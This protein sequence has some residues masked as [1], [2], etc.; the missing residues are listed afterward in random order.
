MSALTVRAAADGTTDTGLCD[1]DLQLDSSGQ[2]FPVT[3]TLGNIVTNLLYLKYVKIVISQ[4]GSKVIQIHITTFCDLSQKVAE[5][6]KSIQP[7]FHFQFLFKCVLEKWSKIK[8][9]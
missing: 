8:Y 9:F 4:P 7:F 1:Q 2:N 3:R 6:T 5:E